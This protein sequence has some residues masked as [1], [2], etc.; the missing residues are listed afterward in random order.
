[1][2]WQ[3]WHRHVVCGNHLDG[4]LVINNIETAFLRG[5]VTLG[6]NFRWKRTSPTYH[7]WCQKTTGTA[8]SCGIKILAESSYVL[9]QSMC[10]RNVD[11]ETMLIV[12]LNKLIGWCKHW[13]LK[14]TVNNSLNFQ[15]RFDGSCCLSRTAVRTICCPLW[16]PLAENSKQQFE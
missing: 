2:M 6:A 5:W 10:D 15:W 13:N 1:M 12:F 8:L 14:T 11:R 9:S 3:L 7:C 4:R 16:R